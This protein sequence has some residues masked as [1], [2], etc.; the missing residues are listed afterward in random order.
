MKQLTVG[1]TGKTGI[2]LSDWIDEVCTELENSGGRRVQR[3]DEHRPAADQALGEGRADFSVGCTKVG[4][5]KIDSW[6]YLLQ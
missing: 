2:V 6:D 4:P 1:D 3:K 5:T